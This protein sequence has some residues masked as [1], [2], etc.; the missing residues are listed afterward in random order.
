MPLK[1]AYLLELGAQK[2][3]FIKTSHRNDKN[4]AVWHNQ[5]AL[6]D[7]WVIFGK[8]G[9]LLC[10][11]SYKQIGKSFGNYHNHRMRYYLLKRLLQLVECVFS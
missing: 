8:P 3:Y 11:R 2:I 10:K 7:L 4:R 1:T 5:T 9:F 6:S